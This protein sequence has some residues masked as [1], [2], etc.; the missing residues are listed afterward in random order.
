MILT[1]PDILA[2]KGG[3]P[4]VALTAYHTHTARLLDPH[5]DLLL[6][7]DSLGMVL[8][9]HANTLPVTL[10]A[11]I[12]HAQAVRRGV[13]KAFVVVDLPFGSY[14]ES[15]E[16]ALRSSVRVLKE[17]NCGA[18]KLEGG[19]RMAETIAFLVE[20]G[21]PVMGHVGL[22]PQSIHVYGQFRAQGRQMEE[23]PKHIA[24]AKAVDDAGAFAM[25]VEAV[26]EP[27]AVEIT[28]AVRAPT[29]GIGA[30]NA[31]DGQILVL[32]DL[33]G[34]TP[35]APK[36]VKPY[37]NVAA[38]IEDAVQRFASDVRSRAFPAKEQTYS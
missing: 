33:L 13:E 7:G 31:C 25:V 12:L 26:A 29:F 37:A 4:L 18:V 10:D 1:A 15:K 20:R 35:R 38:V 19:V 28:H 24:D 3:E 36:F 23:W 9:G 17:T 8:H 32:E 5:V 16:Q 34:L 27:L 21:I 22:T 14:E 30:S 6:V 11:I 2:R